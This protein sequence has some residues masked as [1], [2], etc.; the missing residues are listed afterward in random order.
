VE[1]IGFRS[2]RIRNLDGHLVTVPNKTMGNATIINV[3]LR[4]S[5]K[6]VM[7]FGLTYDTTPEKIQRASAIITKAFQG[8][9]TADLQVTFDKFTDSTLNIQVVYWW[10]GGEYKDYLAI[11]QKA[12][13]EIMARFSQEGIDFAFPTSTVYLKQDASQNPVPAS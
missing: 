2:T 7:N 9:M 12:N 8:P 11:L 1:T 10:K 3:T 4:P 6:T 5:M 13:L